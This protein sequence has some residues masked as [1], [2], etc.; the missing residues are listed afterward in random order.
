MIAFFLERFGAIES[1]LVA[2]AMLVGSFAV[3]YWAR[4]LRGRALEEICAKTRDNFDL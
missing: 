3:V 2:L 1:H 4:V